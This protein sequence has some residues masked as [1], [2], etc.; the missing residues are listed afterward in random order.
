MMSRR[1]DLA[2]TRP[3]EDNTRRAG[4]RGEAD[5][6]G[7]PGSDP[8][9]GAASVAR[10]HASAV[11][12]ITARKSTVE[13]RHA[14]GASR[15]RQ[16]HR[17]LPIPGCPPAGDGL[18]SSGTRRSSVP[19]EWSPWPGVCA[20]STAVVPARPPRR[21]AGSAW[22]LAARRMDCASAGPRS[23]ISS[24][25]TSVLADGFPRC[26]FPPMWCSSYEFRPAKGR[27]P[28]WFRG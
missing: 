21:L 26:P 20:C 28:D 5:R 3:V 9:S 15:A 23:D 8:R 6:G 24:R 27:C 2:Q 14:S 10:R 22:P 1:S 16:S 17:V 4:P 19:G 11:A 13:I 12:T 18:T 7:W 25:S